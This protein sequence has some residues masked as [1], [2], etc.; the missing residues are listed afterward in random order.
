[1][2]SPSLIKRGTLI[3]APVSSVTNLSPPWAVLPFM[4]GGASVTLKSILTGNSIVR[5]F[6]PYL[7]AF[8][9]VLSFSHFVASPKISSLRENLFFGFLSSENPSK[10]CFAEFERVNQYSPRCE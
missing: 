10:F 7:N 8:T 6:S 9:S 2:M 3:L 4:A 1:M 5:I